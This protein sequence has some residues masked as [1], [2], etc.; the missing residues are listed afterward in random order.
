MKPEILLAS[1]DRAELK[2]WE[3]LLRDWK[4][5]CQGVRDVFSALQFLE[6][7]RFFAV[8]CREDLPMTSGEKFARRLE[9]EHS[10]VRLILA[11]G[12]GRNAS[13]P[14]LTRR[15]RPA[16]PAVLTPETLQEILGCLLLQEG[17][18]FQKGGAEY[19]S[20]WK[21]RFPEMVGCSLPIRGIFSL[22][23]KLKDQEVTVLLQGESG[24]GK[25]LAARAIHRHS[26]RAGKPMVMVNCA[27]LPETLLESE[28]FGHEK[29]AF[30]GADARVI[31]RFEQADGG[32]LFLDEVG[33]MS[34]ATQAK[35]LR[36]L[37]GHEFERVGGREGIKVNVRVIAATN[38]NL[39]KLVAEGEF[40]E[41]LYYRLAAFPI[42][43]PPLRDRMEDLPLLTANT[44]RNFNRTAPAPVES[45]EP[46]ALAKLLNHSWPG[47]IRELENVVSRAAILSENGVLTPG[48]IQIESAPFAAEVLPPAVKFEEGPVLPL[49]ELEKEAVRAALKKNRMNVSRTAAQLGIT[50]ATL[51]KKVKDY[52]IEISR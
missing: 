4:I 31:G 38:K 52:G 42:E 15:D 35:V 21:D 5:P 25:E 43:I 16:V 39:K 49:S 32:C 28:L 46:A 41:D 47:N 20:P 12:K 2:D 45:V 50:R 30:T 40:R 22:I 10:G 44:I 33:D 6:I 36:V 37:E 17:V 14:E 48:Q 26:R 27:A 24:T 34:L 51:Y 11:A 3:S 1:H 13:R 29:G 8:I 18:L 7:K 23:L 9:K 19:F